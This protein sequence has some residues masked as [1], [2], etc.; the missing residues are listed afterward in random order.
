[1]GHMAD[2]RES[3]IANRKLQIGSALPVQCPLA[4]PG[5]TALAELIFSMLE[6]RRL[7]NPCLT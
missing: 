4:M 5:E 1:M 2:L 3:Q 6:E 7:V